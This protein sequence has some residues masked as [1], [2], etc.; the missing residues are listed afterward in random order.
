M[1]QTQRAHTH[2]HTHTDT[3]THTHTKKQTSLNSK[4]LIKQ[5]HESGKENQQNS[6]AA[7]TEG[8]V[9]RRQ[10][11]Q[12]NSNTARIEGRQSRRQENQQSSNAS[13]TEGRQ[14]RR[15]NRCEM[16][17][18]WLSKTKTKIRDVMWQYQPNSRILSTPRILSASLLTSFYDDRGSDF[19]HDNLSILRRNAAFCSAIDCLGLRLKRPSVGK[20][21]TTFLPRIDKSCPRSEFLS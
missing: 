3:H 21:D 15:Y 14:S 13:R 5:K 20:Q 1:T 9:S 10:E 11:N 19:G 2:T 4:S 7:R 16:H 17:T 12:Q 6:N 18:N 8:R